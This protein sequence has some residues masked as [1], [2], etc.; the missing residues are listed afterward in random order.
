MVRKDL[1][2]YYE[3]FMKELDDISMDEE[4]QNLEDSDNDDEIDSDVE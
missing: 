4:A 2:K 1:V 3:K